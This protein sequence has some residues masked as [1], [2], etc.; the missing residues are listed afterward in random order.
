MPQSIEREAGPFERLYLCGLSL[1]GLQALFT[2][3]K[4]PGVFSGVLAQSPS[5]WWRDEWLASWMSSFGTGG[6]RFWLSVGSDEVAED[7]KH[8]PTSL[9]QKASQLD[10]VRRLSLAMSRAGHDVD[11]QEFDG[12]HDPAC[13]GEELTGALAWLVAGRGA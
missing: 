1:S 3:L 9:H 2:A 8:P 12:G 6:Q 5:A 11:L 4:H 10:S 13:W 7:L